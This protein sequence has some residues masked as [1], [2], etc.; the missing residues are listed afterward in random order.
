[1]PYTGI[2]LATLR[3][4]TRRS[5]QLSYSNLLKSA[6]LWY[7]L[8]WAYVSYTVAYVLQLRMRE[9]IKRFFY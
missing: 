6:C 2:E 4:L 8:S 7:R 5:S 1:M 9:T 3:I